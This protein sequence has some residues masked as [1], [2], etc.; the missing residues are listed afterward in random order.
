MAIMPKKY[1][2]EVKDR[3]RL[4]EPQRP[5]ARHRTSPSSESFNPK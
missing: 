1:P 4:C 3:A 2:T 5:L